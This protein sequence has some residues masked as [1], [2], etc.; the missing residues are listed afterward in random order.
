MDKGK[1]DPNPFSFK[2][3]LK[4]GEGGPPGPPAAKAGAAAAT[5]KKTGIRKKGS[6]KKDQ[7][8]VFPIVDDE[9][10]GTGVCRD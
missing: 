1:S 10:T 6:V 7:G 5:T 3:F 2:T 8:E 9:D 4:R